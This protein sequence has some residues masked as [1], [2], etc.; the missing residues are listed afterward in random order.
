MERDG[1]SKNI[2]YRPKRLKKFTQTR[3]KT[4]QKTPPE[5][6]IPRLTVPFIYDFSRKRYPFQY[7]VQNF[8]SLLTAVYKCTV[9]FLHRNQSQKQ[10]VHRRFI[11]LFVPTPLYWWSVNP[12]R[13]IFYHPRSTGFEKE[14]EGLCQAI[15]KTE[16]FLDFLKPYHSSISPTGPFNRPK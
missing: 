6:P 7:L 5:N 9:F 8:V 10:P 2:L 11:F 13:F 15:L 12:L 1:K 3:M 16:R 14:I 4:K